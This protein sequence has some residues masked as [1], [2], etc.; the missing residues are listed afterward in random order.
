MSVFFLYIVLLCAGSA[1]LGV[2]LH[3]SSSGLDL[4]MKVVDMFGCCLPVCAIHFSWWAAVVNHAE[5]GL[6]AFMSC[7]FSLAYMNW[8]STRRT[9]WSSGTPR[10]LQNS[11]RCQTQIVVNHLGHVYSCGTLVYRTILCVCVLV[12]AIRVSKFTEQTGHVQE[13]PAHLQRAA[14]GRQLGPDGSASDRCSLTHMV[15]PS[16]D[17]LL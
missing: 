11:S 8:W 6:L 16:L 14:L 1:D 12:P 9:D 2:C 13:E 17:L 4:P 15:A 10:N 3:T 5:T 7:L